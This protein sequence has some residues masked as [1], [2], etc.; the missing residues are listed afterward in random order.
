MLL[1]S[2]LQFLVYL[3][4]FSPTTQSHRFEEILVKVL[5]GKL[6]HTLT[7]VY[8]LSCPRKPGKI[9]QLTHPA[10]AFVYTELL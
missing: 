6:L 8:T 10:W 2:N 1:V 3:Y 5:K 9:Q 4:P 7:I